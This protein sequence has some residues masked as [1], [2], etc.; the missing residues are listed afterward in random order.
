MQNDLRCRL[1]SQIAIS[2]FIHLDCVSCQSCEIIVLIGDSMVFLSCA[3]F[4][5]SI[6]WVQG[7]G[8]W[9]QAFMWIRH[10][11]AHHNRTCMKQL[12]S[13]CGF[14]THFCSRNMMTEAQATQTKVLTCTCPALTLIVPI[15]ARWW[16]TL[17][18]SQW[19]MRYSNGLWSP[20]HTVPNKNVHIVSGDYPTR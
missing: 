7:N 9:R 16:S 8:I 4:W 13:S 3:S 2:K 20:A 5:N 18:R 12:D 1:Q 11:A 17:R 6:G 10:P 14:V 15:L 19:S